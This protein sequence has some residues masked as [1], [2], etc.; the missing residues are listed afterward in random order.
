MWQTVMGRWDASGGVVILE[1]QGRALQAEETNAKNLKPEVWC[2]WGTQGI[3]E[4]VCINFLLLLYEITR[5][6]VT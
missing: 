1:F 6:L 4:R 5:N 2:V 3:S